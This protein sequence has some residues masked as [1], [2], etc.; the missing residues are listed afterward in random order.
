[1]QHSSLPSFFFSL[2]SSFPSSPS[3]HSLPSLS[4]IVS[5][6]FSY[7]SLPSFPS[8]SCFL[9]FLF[10][11]PSFPNF[12]SST[13]CVFVLF[14]CSSPSSSTLFP[15]SGVSRWHGLGRFQPG[16]SRWRTYRHGNKLHFLWLLKKMYRA[17]LQECYCHYCS[18]VWSS[19]SSSS[20]Y[21]RI[22]SL[23]FSVLL[24]CLFFCCWRKLMAI[25]GTVRA[26]VSLCACRV[27]GVHSRLYEPLLAGIQLPVESQADGVYPDWHLEEP[28][29]QRQAAEEHAW[30][31]L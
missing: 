31:A 16:L 6:L 19:R 1:M 17:I 28:D 14:L 22:N 15:V 8:F 25:S 24:T 11:F 10:Y 18:S 29:V 4:P 23:P 2:P 7:S 5:F 21:W 12:T 20:V 9:S 30:W 27:P 3:S 26:A 13:S